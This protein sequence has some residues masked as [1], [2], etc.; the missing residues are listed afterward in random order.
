VDRNAAAAIAATA[1]KRAGPI[2]VSP[3]EAA[4]GVMP[5]TTI[6]TTWR[7]YINRFRQELTNL[8]LI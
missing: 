7:T 4:Q 8:E 5:N 1:S 6:A 2:E 3:G